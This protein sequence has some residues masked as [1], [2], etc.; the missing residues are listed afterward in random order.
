MVETDKLMTAQT[1]SKRGHGRQGGGHSGK[2]TVWKT[3]RT[4]FS[5]ATIPKNPSPS[6][7]SRSTVCSADTCV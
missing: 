1:G 3:E 4:V 5:V 6:G 2:R 7:V